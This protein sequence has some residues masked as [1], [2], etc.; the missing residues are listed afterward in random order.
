MMSDMISLEFDTD[1]SFCASWM[2]DAVANGANKGM[3]VSQKQ[4]ADFVAEAKKLRKSASAETDG[5]QARLNVLADRVYERRDQIVEF[6]RVRD[7]AAGEFHKLTGR[8]WK[9]FVAGN[10]VTPRDKTATNA[11]WDEILAA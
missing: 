11:A 4:V 1:P 7:A 10:S 5:T 6:E 8:M 9:P 3:L 2:L